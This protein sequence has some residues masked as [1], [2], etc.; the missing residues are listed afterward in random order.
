[1]DQRA[2]E[3]QTLTAYTT[4]EG[5]DF[6][7]P[8]TKGQRKTSKRKRAKGPAK[9]KATTA[10]KRKAGTKAAA[11]AKASTA[12]RPSGTRSQAKRPRRARA[13]ATRLPREVL[14]S[15]EDGQRAA[16]DAVRKFVDTVESALPPRA[17][18]APRRQEIVDSAM[19]MAERLVQTQYDVLRKVVRSAGKTVGDS[20]KRG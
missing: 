18:G 9:A 11:R 14:K 10:A 4:R 20:V 6:T 2:L 19:E 12:A 1:M 13:S 7:M 16:V 3:L 8:D 17:E 5:T 15:F